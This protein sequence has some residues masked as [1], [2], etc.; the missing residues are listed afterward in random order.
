M[1]GSM[2]TLELS[3][4]VQHKGPRVNACWHPLLDTIVNSFVSK[5]ANLDIGT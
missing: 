3:M 1:L 4:N 5:P 2:S